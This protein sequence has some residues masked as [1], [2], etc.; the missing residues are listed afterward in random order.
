MEDY[1][2]TLSDDAILVAGSREDII[3]ENGMAC[4]RMSLKI[5]VDKSIVLVVRKVQRTSIEKVKVN[6]E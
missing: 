6:R 3:D 1:T 4:D 5:C 2:R